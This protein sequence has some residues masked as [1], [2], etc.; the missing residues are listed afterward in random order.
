MKERMILMRKIQDVEFALTELQLYLDT[1]PFDQKALMDFNCYSQQL[2]ML[3]QQYEMSY[4]P[5]LQY[6]FSPSPY[7]W[8]WLD[9][10]WPW[11]EEF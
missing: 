2:L 1:H 11:E 8:K 5:L 4:G 6:G 10:P 9:S 3:K 7:P